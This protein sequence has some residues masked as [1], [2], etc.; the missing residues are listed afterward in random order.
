MIGGAQSRHTALFRHK[1]KTQA[2]H[3][4]PSATTSKD[5][6]RSYTHCDSPVDNFYAYSRSLSAKTVRMRQKRRKLW[7]TQEK[8]LSD[9]SPNKHT[10][11]YEIISAAQKI[12]QGLGEPKRFARYKHPL[13]LI[14]RARVNPLPRQ[15][16]RNAPCRRIDVCAHRHPAEIL[17][18]ISP[19]SQMSAPTG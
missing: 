6:P 14:R 16:S 18:R 4:F 11:A 2:P 5:I 12:K 19:P 9:K 17:S 15:R 13:S 10:Q 1:L 3:R 8:I 7:I